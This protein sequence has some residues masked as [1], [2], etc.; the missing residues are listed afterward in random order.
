MKRKRG[1]LHRTQIKQNEYMEYEPTM[2]Y[3]Y[4]Y[5]SIYIDNFQFHHKC[6]LSTL[7]GKEFRVCYYE[8]LEFDWSV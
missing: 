3:I 4:M 2:Y 1:I 5:I 8:M 6:L 7:W